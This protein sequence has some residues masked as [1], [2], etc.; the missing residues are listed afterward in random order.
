MGTSAEK[1]WTATIKDVQHIAQIVQHS[2]AADSSDAVATTLAIH[3]H[4]AQL[5]RQPP[6]PRATWKKL[7]MNLKVGCSRCSRPAAP[8]FSGQ[9]SCPVVSQMASTAAIARVA[10]YSCCTNTAP[11]K[12]FM[13]MFGTSNA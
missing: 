10:L 3:G 9:D 4:L 12:T 6:Y 13:I 1:L 7:V 5:V 2:G 8:G 11:C